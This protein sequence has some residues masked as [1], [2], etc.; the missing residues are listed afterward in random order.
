[1][2]GSRRVP[3]SLAVLTAGLVGALLARP[4]WQARGTER[5]AGEPT[6]VLV[7]PPSPECR[8]ITRRIAAKAELTELLCR[9]ELSLFQTA[10]CFRALH[11]EQG[12]YASPHWVGIPGQTEEEKLCRQ[13][14]QWASGRLP[15][16]RSGELQG[17][18]ERELAEHIARE[19][20]VVLPP[21]PMP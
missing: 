10:A 17:R 5:D 11:G 16:D 7:F 15:Q 2:I 21:A 3:V 14:I 20:R 18:L 6:S 1:M 8:M 13:V 4:G 19:G 12:G 9:G